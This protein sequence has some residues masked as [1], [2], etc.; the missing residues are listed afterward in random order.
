MLS[1]HRPDKIEGSELSSISGKNCTCCN[2]IVLITFMPFVHSHASIIDCD[3]YLVFLFRVLRHV[4]LIRRSVGLLKGLTYSYSYYFCPPLES[5]GWD[6]DRLNCRCVFP[7][8]LACLHCWQILYHVAMLLLRPLHMTLVAICRL[9]A[10]V[11][12][13]ASLWKAARKSK[14]RPAVLAEGPLGE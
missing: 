9:V 7:R 1:V 4:V 10:C 3:M 8:G 11:P 5:P 2:F 13:C 12:V 6:S 14:K